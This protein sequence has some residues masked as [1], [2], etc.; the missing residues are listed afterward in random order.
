MNRGTPPSLQQQGSLYLVG[1]GVSHALA[2][3]IH[4]TVIRQIGANW[5][6]SNL[7][8]K[9]KE[10]ALSY[11]RK[12]DFI[13]C[14]PTMPLKIQLLDVVE[15]MDEA[16]KAI[17]AI[18]NIYKRDDKLLGANTDWIG[19]LK[20]LKPHIP[21]DVDSEGLIVGA[22]GA[23][24]AAVYALA[25][26]GLKTIYI[27]NRDVKEVNDLKRDIEKGFKLASIIIPKLIHL[28]TEEQAQQNFN[29]NAKERKAV[30]IGVS[31][32]PDL[33]PSSESEKQASAVLKITLS[34]NNGI[35][36]E[37]AYKP[38]VT[39]TFAL[40]EKH[41]WKVVE[42]INVIAEQVQAVWQLFAGVNLSETQ[43]KAAQNELWRQASTRDELNCN[44][45][46]K[47]AAVHT[48]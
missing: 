29:V 43:I 20:S 39:R 45:I 41:N 33:E 30:L 28:E 3:A 31:C 25:K 6:F 12:D 48:K 18:N 13:G 11:I 40:A 47:S 37:M 9:S 34:Q 15:E 26:L 44:G 1:S 21:E 46:P 32:V 38:R 4:N 22:G 2:P 23:S 42:G 27:I 14:V 5:T 8:V 36:L 24:R 17:G 19:I 35:L 7:D 16:A 10:E